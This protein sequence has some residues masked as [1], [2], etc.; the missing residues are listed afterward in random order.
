MH[1]IEIQLFTNVS[2]DTKT[3][4]KQTNVLGT[5]RE[6]QCIIEQLCIYCNNSIQS[7]SIFSPALPRHF[8]ILHNVQTSNVFNSL[9][10]VWD[11]KY[12]ER[13][14]IPGVYLVS[15]YSGVL[16]TH[17]QNSIYT[18]YACAIA[19]YILYRIFEKWI[20]CWN[21]YTWRTTSLYL[22][23]MM[24]ESRILRCFSCYFVRWWCGEMHPIRPRF[25]ANISDQCPQQK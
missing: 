1:S 4:Q 20:K 8:G 18:L 13:V 11:L 23:A 21:Q 5:I 3:K 9:M 19:Q 15:T 14:N 22:K 7:K 10:H 16:L 24:N 17:E 25:V 6:V 12:S 2:L